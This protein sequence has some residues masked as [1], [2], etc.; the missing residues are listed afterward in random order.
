MG[1]LYSHLI[2]I[3][4]DLLCVHVFVCMSV[5]TYGDQRKIPTNTFSSP[6]LGPEDWTWIF[7]LDIKHL[8][9]HI[10]PALHLKVLNSWIRDPQ[11]KQYI[12]S[13]S[14]AHSTAQIPSIPISCFMKPYY[15]FFK[16]GPDKMVFCLLHYNVLSINCVLTNCVLTRF[17]G[18]Y[19]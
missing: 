8:Y 4:V 1:N 11:L 15:M 6:R 5:C 7:R 19:L 14:E 2:L 16:T 9:L 13:M 18:I 12:S 10:L 17:V 3:L